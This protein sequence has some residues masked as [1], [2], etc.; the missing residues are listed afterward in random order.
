MLQL[1]PTELYVACM[2]LRD[3]STPQ[4]AGKMGVSGIAVRQHVI[5]IKDKTGIKTHAALGAYLASHQVSVQTKKET[6]CISLSSVE[7]LAWP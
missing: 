2:M 5:R 1:T 7:L 3:Y 6:V 4:I